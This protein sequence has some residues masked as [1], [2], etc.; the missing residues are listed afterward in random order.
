MSSPEQ[1]R[2]SHSERQILLDL[3]LASIQHGLSAGKALRVRARDYPLALQQS[4][5]SFVTLQRN[6]Q[7]R[8]CI[9]HL[10]PLQSLVE[11]IAENA[12]SAA[13]RDPRFAP[14]AA[15]EL[16][17]L[18]I[19]LSVLSAP[20]ALSF[21]SE[22]DLLAQLRPGVDGLILQDGFARGTFLPSVWESLPRAEDFWRQLKRKAGLPSSHW[23]SSL[24]VQRYETES[25][26]DEMA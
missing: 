19:H 22:Q 16:E 26:S 11:D 25:F 14:L 24:T 3:A 2:L 21:S 9:G 7:L 23:S 15:H 6:G 10:Q 1:Q 17:N 5:A 18:H 4:R 20:Q 12:W 8:G 13:F